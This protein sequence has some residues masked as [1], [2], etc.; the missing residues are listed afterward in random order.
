MCTAGRL[1]IE[2]A[3]GLDEATFG[4]DAVAIAD[5]IAAADTGDGVVVLMDLGSAVLSA[6]LALE[7]LDDPDVRDRVLLCPA[8]LVEGLVVAAVPPRRAA[9][10]GREVAA[11]AAGG[12]APASV[13]QLAPA[14]RRRHAGRRAPAGSWR[15]RGGSADPDA[16]RK[17]SEIV[18]A[19][20]TVANPH[21]LHAR[22]GGRRTGRRWS[23]GVRRHRGA[24]AQR[25][26][27]ARRGCR[28]RACRGSPR[29]R[30]L[31]GHSVE[32]RHRA[33]GREAVVDA[34]PGRWPRAASTRRPGAARP[35]PAPVP[36]AAS[37]RPRAAASPGIGIGPARPLR[38]APVALP[39]EPA[40]RPGHR[41]L[42]PARGRARRGPPTTIRAVRDHRPRARPA[43]AAIFDAHLLLLDDPDLLAAARTRI[44]ARARRPR[45]ALGG[46]RRREG[47]R[48]RRAAR[49]LPRGA[50]APTS[51]RSA[52]PGAA[53]RSAACRARRSRRAARRGVLVAA[54]LTPAEAAALD[55]ARVPAVVLAGG[56]PTAH[57]AILLRARGM[58]AVVGGGRG[59]AARSP[60]A[61]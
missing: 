20:V 14:S 61:R 54:D 56:S 46:G 3:A 32:V 47:G 39:D 59:G 37:T 9:P 43:E 1:P 45:P 38:D 2:V 13:A 8:P 21:G 44:D 57:S 19:A 12:A 60:T 48:G 40:A 58:P 53:Q 7:L 24:A 18:R 6:E 4:T 50:R 26:A 23:A 55:P 17:P 22:P 27:P 51:A 10:T 31:R 41:A 15:S 36:V 28:R 42:A 52:R 25:H 30:A 49:P 34:R 29:W 35:Q 16:P 11:E 33:A 5:A